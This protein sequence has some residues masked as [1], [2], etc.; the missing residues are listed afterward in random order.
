MFCKAYLLTFTFAL[1]TAASPVKQ[2]ASGISIPL[3][4]RS[5]LTKPDGTFDFQKA[6]LHR[7][8]I[9]KYVTAACRNSLGQLGKMLTTISPPASKYRRNNL[10]LERNSDDVFNEV[11]PNL[12][13]NDNFPLQY[14]IEFRVQ[15]HRLEL[16]FPRRCSADI[17]YP[18]RIRKRR[19][20]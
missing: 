3:L 19:G 20:G 16:L 7:I 5:T 13:A 15:K 14:V 4:K 18:L 10:N 12:M 17:N 8:A 6:D 11:S 9:A 1:L 2:T